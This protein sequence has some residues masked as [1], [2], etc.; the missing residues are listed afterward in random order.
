[1]TPAF[2]AASLVFTGLCVGCLVYL[3]LAPTGYSPVRHAVSRYGVGAYH[4]WYEAQAAC[5]GIAGILLAVALRHP[6]HVVVLL[7]VFGGARLAITQFPMDTR[8]GG[9][10]LLAIVAFG[11]ATSA[12]IRLPAS[13]HGT[14]PLG[15]AMLAAL[16]AGILL[17]ELAFGL[18]ERA[19]YLAM[20]AWLVLVAT[21]LV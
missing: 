3:H 8:R 11:S 19:F 10:A 6:R 21:R 14:P 15:W 9:H 12:A 4:R 2:A 5:A 1:V 16:V 18:A 7:V 20:L 13:L 17:R